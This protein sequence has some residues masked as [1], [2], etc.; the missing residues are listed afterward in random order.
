MLLC[1]FQ[2]LFLYVRFSLL[3][4]IIILLLRFYPPSFT[5][6]AHLIKNIYACQDAPCPSQ[7]KEE[8][9]FQVFT[10]SAGIFLFFPRTDGREMPPPSFFDFSIPG[11]NSIQPKRILE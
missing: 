10:T 9:S 4:L 3:L 6:Y 7:D 8:N 5:H 2:L 11:N 1:V